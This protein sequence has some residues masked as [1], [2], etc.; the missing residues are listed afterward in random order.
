[1][2]WLRS[3]SPLPAGKDASKEPRWNVRQQKVGCDE[4]HGTTA[5]EDHRNT[6]DQKTHANANCKLHVVAGRELGSD[7]STGERS[8]RVSQKRRKKI[9]L[10]RLAKA[11][12]APLK[13]SG[14]ADRCDLAWRELGATARSGRNRVPN[15]PVCLV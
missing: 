7:E 11:S 9:E 2:Q 4:P 13:S 8:E 10:P 6:A 12:S 14:F 5:H 15:W 1:M 3:L